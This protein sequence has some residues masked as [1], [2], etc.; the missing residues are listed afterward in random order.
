MENKRCGNYIRIYPSQGSSVY[1]AYFEST[2]NS[3]KFLYQCLYG[4][5]L[6]NEGSDPG[7]VPKL[8]S[9]S[10]STPRPATEHTKI[11]ITSDDALIEYLT[12]LAALTKSI[13]AESFKQVW[14]RSI[15]N[16]LSNP[17]WKKSIDLRQ[18]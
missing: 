5:L 10:K 9:Q 16:F 14:K 11:L 6:F 3:N 18:P 12:R 2:R 13:S 8:I 15:L 4:K 7:K 17:L 1:E